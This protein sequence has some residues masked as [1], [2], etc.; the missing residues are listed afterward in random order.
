MNRSIHPVLWATLGSLLIAGAPLGLHA[1]TTAPQF[2]PGTVIDTQTGTPINGYG[3]SV[4][5]VADLNVDGHLDLAVSF[6]GIGQVMVRA[7][8]GQGGFGFPVYHSVGGNAVSVISG[9]FN[10]D[11][12]PDLV[13]TNS[14]DFTISILRSTLTGYLPP[15]TFVTGSMPVRAYDA[16]LNE[17]GHLD[18]VVVDQIDSTVGLLLGNGQGSFAP[19]LTSFVEIDDSLEALT[20]EDLDGDGHLDLII[21]CPV[22]D[23]VAVLLGLGNGT[24]FSPQ[25]HAVGAN[26]GPLA[27]EDFDGDGIRDVLVPHRSGGSVSWLRG[28]GGGALAP[29][30]PLLVGGNPQCAK[31]IQD[32][33]GSASKAALPLAET[34]AFAVVGHI[35]LG[36]PPTL[37][38]YQTPYQPELIETGDFDEDGF[39]DLAVVSRVAG[40]VQIYL[41]VATETESLRGDVDG[42]GQLALVDAFAI[43]DV[44]FATGQSACPDRVDANDDGRLDIADA[45]RVLSVMFGGAASLPTP[46]VECGVD[47]TEDTL[48][49][50]DEG[51]A[52]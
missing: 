14:T 3:Y 11:G 31:E 45:V 34:Y 35:A 29:A 9:D 46:G 36:S 50:C 40:V 12:R 52:P 37:E 20:I 4:L 30:V 15:L 25:G 49:A 8:D 5:E 17:D 24:F 39:D 51:C 22:L 6:T 48:A 27:V 33:G 41:Q 18:L 21:P 26:P 1:Q 19:V 47:P 2:V 28:L 10:E 16:D 38:T 32:S 43:L 42:D 44:V 23:M 13:T 7:G